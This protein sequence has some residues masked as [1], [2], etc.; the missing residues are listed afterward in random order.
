MKEGIEGGMPFDLMP[1]EEGERRRKI[2]NG[3]AKPVSHHEDHVASL[4]KGMADTKIDG[5]ENGG[6]KAVPGEWDDEGVD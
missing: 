3:T 4:E 5:K 6:S 1:A 2:A